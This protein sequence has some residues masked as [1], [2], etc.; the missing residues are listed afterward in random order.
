VDDDVR[1][2]KLRNGI[3][4]LSSWKDTGEIILVWNSAKTVLTECEK[5][6]QLME[7]YST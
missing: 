2:K 5:V 6:S 3:K 4:N 1:L 7:Y